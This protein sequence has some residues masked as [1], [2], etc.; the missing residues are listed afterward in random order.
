MRRSSHTLTKRFADNNTK[1]GITVSLEIKTLVKDDLRAVIGDLA[2]LR[3][4]VFRE[5]P[6]LYDGSVEYE[7]NYLS[8]YVESDSCVLVAAIDQGRLVGAAT[9]QPLKMETEEFR[10]PFEEKGIDISKVFYL[11]ESVL[12]P[13][14]RHHGIGHR[15][16]DEREAF[17][18]R[19]GYKTATFC[20]VVRDV[21]DPR[22]P[23]EY[24]SLEPFWQKRG[25]TKR[26][27]LMTTFPWKE[28]GED[29]ESDKPMQFWLHD[30]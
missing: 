13:D 19:A 21:A 12:E 1:W 17:A 4:S 3:I 23:E 30:F 14:Y 9:A 20:A 11:A 27:G 8:R 25:Y 26:E 24:F 22:K 15:F 7:E 2:K 10:R 16:F 18:S 29:K 28:L 5:W 6:Y